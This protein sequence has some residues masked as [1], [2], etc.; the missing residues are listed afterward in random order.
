[1]LRGVKDDRVILFKDG[2][3]YVF[4][5]SRLSERD[6]EYVIKHREENQ[7]GVLVPS[8]SQGFPYLTDK[9]LAIAPKISVEVLEKT[10]LFLTNEFR[11]TLNVSELKK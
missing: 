7:A 5:L 2:R 1:M 3:E 4:P 11:K 10:V 8:G 6:H 9:E